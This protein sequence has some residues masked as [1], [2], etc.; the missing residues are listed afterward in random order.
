MGISFGGCVIDVCRNRVKS[1]GFA[2]TCDNIVVKR[3]GNGQHESG[4]DS[5]NNLRQNDFKE[6][7]CGTCAEIKGGFVQAAVHLLKLWYNGK[8]YKRSADDHMTDNERKKGFFHS[9]G[10]E[11]DG[12]CKRSNDFR[13]NNGNL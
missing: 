10:N 5:W 8:Y 9:Y 12:K 2:V 4:N 7:F 11:R 13:V 1:R 6:R 3:K